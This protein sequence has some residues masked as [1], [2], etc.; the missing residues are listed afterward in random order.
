MLVGV[1]FLSLLN[2]TPQTLYLIVAAKLYRKFDMAT[3][4]LNAL[5]NYID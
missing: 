2:G 4:S 1:L 5:L 3:S